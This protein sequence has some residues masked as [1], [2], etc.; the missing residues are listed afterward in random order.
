[1]LTRNE[2]KAFMG[3][4]AIGEPSAGVRIRIGHLLRQE[5]VKTALRARDWGTLNRKCSIPVRGG[6]SEG[7]GKGGAS[8]EFEGEERGVAARVSGSG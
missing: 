1:M 6:S 4:G 7:R 2:W 8:H 5:L 3:M